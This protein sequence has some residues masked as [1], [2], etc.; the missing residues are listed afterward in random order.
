MKENNMLS[1]ASEVFEPIVIFARASLA[2]SQQSNGLPML[3]QW[4]T[5]ARADGTPSV[6]RARNFN[7]TNGCTRPL[8][9]QNFVAVAL[10]V[11]E[12]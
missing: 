5:F 7:T 10:T 12:Q 4:R 6:T 2:A 11:S 8:P 3:N 9:C 1:F